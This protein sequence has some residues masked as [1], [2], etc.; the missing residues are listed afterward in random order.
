MVYRRKYKKI[1]RNH[2]LLSYMRPK[3]TNSKLKQTP[4][5]K[6]K[7]FHPKICAWLVLK[8]ISD[9]TSTLHIVT[10]PLY[11]VTHKKV[12]VFFLKSLTNRRSNSYHN[13]LCSQYLI[14]KTEMGIE[15]H[16]QN[17]K[18]NARYITSQHFS[19]TSSEMESLTW[20]KAI[21][22]MCIQNPTY[23]SLSYQFFDS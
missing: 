14:L 21:I 2:K 13:F 8:R 20:R 10:S 23:H 3:Q 19:C 9:P 11:I 17:L 12:N 5:K 4:K 22:I 1:I 15:N 18:T 7:H 16:K 6:I